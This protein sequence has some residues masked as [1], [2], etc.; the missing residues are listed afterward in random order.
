MNSKELLAQADKRIAEVDKIRLAR[1]NIVDLER[2]MKVSQDD[3]YDLRY[4]GEYDLP[5]EQSLDVDNFED[6][7]G[8]LE[9]T[10]K[11]YLLVQTVKLEQLLGIKPMILNPEF[12]AAVL[13]MEEQHT[14]KM[15]VVETKNAKCVVVQ[16]DP[17]EAKLADIFQKQAQEI[18]GE[19]IIPEDNDKYPAKPKD[20]RCKYP[21]NMN[22]ES[23]GKMYRDERKSMVEI[24]EYFGVKKSTVNNFIYL[25]GLGRKKAE[26]P[27]KNPEETE[28]P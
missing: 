13:G 15:L 25:H 6:L 16:K 7:K 2:L 9:G 10:F 11:R 27:A 19:P 21:D 28:R 26:K 1:Q 4:C 8:I 23:V 12:E 18:Q 22:E 14:E 20:K 5:L 24:A 17:V 3:T